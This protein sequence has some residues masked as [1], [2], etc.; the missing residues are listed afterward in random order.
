MMA[1][2]LQTLMRAIFVI[3]AVLLGSAIARAEPA[4]IRI[5]WAVVPANIGPLMVAKA[6]LAQHSGNSYAPGFIHFA[7]AP[8]QL[9]ALGANEIDIAS[10]AYSTLARGIENGG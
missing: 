1:Q 3:A 10:L 6:G 2:T 4:K 5:G 9:A 7:G 8:Q